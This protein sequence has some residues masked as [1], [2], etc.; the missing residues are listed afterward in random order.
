MSNRHTTRTGVFFALALAFAGTA[1]AEIISVAP[2]DTAGLIEAIEY[3]NKTPGEHVI[4]LAAKSLYA[5]NGSVEGQKGLGLP[6]IRNHVRILGNG[7]EIRR[8]CDEPLLLV[9]VA[10]AGSLRLENVTLAEGA[11]GAIVNHGKVELLHVRLIDNTASNTSAIVT[12]HGELYASDSDISYNQISVARR[13]AGIVLNYGSIEIERTH[14]DSN[15]VG[16][17][18]HSRAE[19]SAILNL[20]E[21]E[22]REISLNNNAAED[23]TGETRMANL[24]N[25][26][27]GRFEAATKVR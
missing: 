4:E 15:W 23:E 8:Y 11:R 19:V 1:H 13:D 20:G 25:L 22:L 21:A 6:T 12:N 16:R 9:S 3:A 14:F 7:S 24:V 17:Q 2:R 5:L 27:E 18:P 10:P 26:G